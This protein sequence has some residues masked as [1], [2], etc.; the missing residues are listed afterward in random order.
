M[1]IEW[2]SSTAIPKPWGRTDLRPWSVLTRG[3]AAIGEIRF[4]RPV[5][6]AARPSLLLKLIFTDAPL[7]IQ[8]HPDDE[9]A[10]AIG[11]PHGK[12]EAW[13]VLD[14]TPQAR[15]GLGLRRRVAAAEL[16]AAVEAATIAD[17]ID[18]RPVAAGDVFAVPGGTI[19]AIGAGLIVAEVQQNNDTTWRLFDHGRGR[20]LDIEAGLAVADAGPMADATASVQLGEGRT[21]LPGVAAFT[22]EKL[23]LPPRAARHLRAERETWLLVIGGELSLAQRPA[24]PGDAIFLEADAVGIEA[25]PAGLRALIAYPGEVQPD[26]VSEA[27]SAAQHR[28]RALAGLAV[29][30]AAAGSHA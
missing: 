11:Q 2:A 29:P 28:P 17:L 10:R 22:V 20:A 5:A 23:E 6:T 24:R 21:L 4:D 18:W 25:G 7:S 27:P 14:A 3:G 13:Y 8:V 1:T 15:I 26:L 9:A 16:R 30:R 12:S 19:H